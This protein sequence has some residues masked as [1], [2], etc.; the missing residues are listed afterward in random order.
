MN[1]SILE[2]FKKLSLSNI[3]SNTNKT[4]GIIKKTIPVYR[5]VKPYMTHEKSLFK[6]DD[7]NIIK[8]S[9]ILK[10]EHTRTNFND[11]LTFFK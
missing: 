11:T 7:S 6:K 5:Q 2:L 3:I 4:L 1:L 10:D 9:K 8:E